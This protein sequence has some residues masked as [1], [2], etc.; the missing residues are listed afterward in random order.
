MKNISLYILSAFVSLAMISCAKEPDKNVTWPEWASRPLVNNAALSSEGGKAVVAGAEVKY[1]ASVNDVYNE[2]K[3]YTLTVNY[4]TNQVISITKTLSGNE[5][6]IE[7]EFVMPFAAYL[8]EGDFYPEVILTVSN[9]AGGFMVQ[10]LANQNNLMVSRPESPENLYVIDNKGNSFTLV[11][12][13]RSLV[14]ETADGADLSS[15]G[16]SFHIASAATVQS[17]SLVWGTEDGKIAVGEELNPIETPES[18]GYGFKKIGFDLYTFQVSK[19]VNH[20]ITLNKEEMTMTEQSGVKYYA[21]ENVNVIRDCEI[22]FEGFEDLKS[23]LQPDRFEIV[24]GTTAKFTGHTHNWSFWYD[25]TD[26]WMIVN[27]AVGNGPDQFWVTGIKACFPLGNEETVNSFD[28]LKGDG[29]DRYA[30]LAAIRESAEDYHILVYL[31]KDFALQLYRWIKWSTVTTMTT[32]TPE[33]ASIT[34]DGIYIMQGS[35]FKPGVYKLSIHV[36]K[37]YDSNGDG[38]EAEISLEPY[39]LK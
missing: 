3:E 26:N 28:Y 14:Y 15:L 22:V 35:D 2:L 27:Y 30:T 4:G 31:K 39:T 18:A 16:E 34:D 11:K 20:S 7:E 38:T 1:S 25:A 23:M 19:T 32:A 36:T 29:K 33:Y 24:D 13:E 8:E 37:A 10:R 12:K 9:T 6:L 17:A 5:A 21:K